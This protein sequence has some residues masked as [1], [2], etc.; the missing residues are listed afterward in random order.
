MPSQHETLSDAGGEAEFQHS[1]SEAAVFAPAQLL[2]RCMDDYHFAADLL[3][4]F[5]D[6]LP[7]MLAE[8][9]DALDLD[10]NATAERKAHFLKGSAG[11]LAA[12]RL[13]QACARL[14]AALRRKELSQRVPLLADVRH[15]VEVFLRAHAQSMEAL[16]QCAEVPV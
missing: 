14:E 5:T 4:M 10:D 7:Q 16:A 13:F 12:P 3:K 2:G 8:V 1:E 9:G 11:D 15:E 6:R